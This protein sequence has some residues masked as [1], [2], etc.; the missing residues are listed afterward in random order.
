MLRL[1][2]EPTSVS[3]VS[4]LK[5]LNIVAADQSRAADEKKQ[6]EVAARGGMCDDELP[7]PA[8][9]APGEVNDSFSLSSPRV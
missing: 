6:S 3:L 8:V 5:L 2:K 4:M 7:N 9:S 1:R